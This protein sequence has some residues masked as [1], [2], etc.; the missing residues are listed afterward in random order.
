MFFYLQFKFLQS[1][2]I[3]EKR[4]IDDSLIKALN[5]LIEN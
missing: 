3:L 4:D 1:L 2:A 5:A